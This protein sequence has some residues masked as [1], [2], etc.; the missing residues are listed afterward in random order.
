MK[1]FSHCTAEYTIQIRQPIKLKGR[2]ANRN[3][4]GERREGKEQQVGVRCRLFLYPVGGS[5]VEI[6]TPLVIALSLLFIGHK[7][8]LFT[9]FMRGIY[10]ENKIS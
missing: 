2:Q 10:K 5:S 9:T 3:G 8:L 1:N 7:T 6:P 4:Q